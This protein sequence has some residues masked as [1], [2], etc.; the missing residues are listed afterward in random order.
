[1]NK[2][3]R[4]THKQDVGSRD[5]SF[6]KYKD[7]SDAGAEEWDISSYVALTS[8]ESRAVLKSA[9]RP[10]A[11]GQDVFVSPTVLKDVMDGTEVHCEVTTASKY[12]LDLVL[13]DPK[14]RA[15]FF[16]AL[17]A[18][19]GVLI[20]GGLTVGKVKPL[21]IVEESTIV[22]SMLGSMTLKI[23]GLFLVLWKGILEGK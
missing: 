22:W 8:G 12:R 5:A 17:V 16:G 4:L 23:V 14:Q 2:T 1:M 6:P 3:W 19:A 21:W 18:L 13:N 7:D 20:D 15:A 11:K 10:H 9:T